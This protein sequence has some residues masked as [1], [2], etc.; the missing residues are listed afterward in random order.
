VP[1]KLSFNYIN[2]CFNSANYELL[3][4]EYINSNYKLK[5]RCP[6]GHIGF[7]KWDHFRDGH[8]CAECG[9]NKKLSIDLIKK[10]FELCGYTLL[11]DVYIN[12]RSK[13]NYKCP[14]GHENSITWDNWHTGYRCPQCSLGVVKDKL[15]LDYDFIKN[16]FEKEG[17]TLLSQTYENAF[18]RLDFICPNG[19]KWGIIWN[20]W[21]HGSR[22]GKC[23]DIK[24]RSEL[25]LLTFIKKLGFT[26][27]E[28]DRQ[29]IAPYELDVVIPEKKLA[30]EYCGLYWHSELAGR[31]KH[32]HNRKLDL[33]A[34]KGYRLITV[35]EDEFIYKRPVVES[36]L[37]SILGY[38]DMRMIYGRSCIIKPISYKET[39]EFCETNH[40]Q[41]YGISKVKLG[42]FYNDELVSVLTFALPSI[43][44]RAKEKLLFVW[45]LSRFCSKI[46]CKVIGI[47]SKLLTYFMRNYRWNCIFSYADRR[48][49]V[50]DLYSKN[51]FV[52]CG[53]TSPSYW[54]FNGQRRIHCFKLRKSKLEL[55]CGTEWSLKKQQNYN[56]IWDCG[57]LKYVRYLSV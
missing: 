12:S 18:Q 24:S 7:I 31:D 5:Y 9:G 3:S 54:Y 47:F 40:I 56:R 15:K 27:I 52:L 21:Q 46:G 16:S 44:K 23:F 41:G 26:C 53:K 2:E 38:S 55:G 17:Y 30:V 11:S 32:Y 42:A 37:K 48:W 57:S 35:F 28:N 34:S 22:C 36:R 20:S 49:S 4:T 8:R 13:L 19:H 14:K 45:E 29:L 33:C 51:G 39:L 6:N 10:D 1:K 43:A 50:G 25:D